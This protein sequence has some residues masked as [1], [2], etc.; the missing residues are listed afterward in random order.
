MCDRT[1][2][3]ELPLPSM[4]FSCRGEEGSGR[5]DESRQELAHVLLIQKV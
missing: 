2:E 1:S 5:R 3:E 4:L